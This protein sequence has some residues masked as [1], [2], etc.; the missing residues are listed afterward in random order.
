VTKQGRCRWCGR[1]FDVAA[2]PGRPREYC[3]RS[4]RQRD[5]E[6]RRRAADVG[7]GDAHLVMARAEVDTLHDRLYEL[8]AAVEDVERDLAAADPP[9]ERDYR[10]ALDWLL[11]VARPLTSSRLGET[12]R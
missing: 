6:A 7:L 8:E 9:G 2:G 1:P 4:C 12:G 10:E 11:S 5:Y 3:R